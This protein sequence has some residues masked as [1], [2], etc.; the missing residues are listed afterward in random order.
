MSEVINTI[1]QTKVIEVKP[2]IR[3][4]A[5]LPA[6][7]DGAGLFT[8]AT[9]GTTLAIDKVRKQFY[10]IFTKDE[11]EAVEK[12]LNKKPGELDFYDRHNIFWTNF[13]V[14]ITKEGLKLDLSRIEDVI[15]YRI[16]LNDPRIAK[17]WT[18][19]F[20]DGRFKSICPRLCYSWII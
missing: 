16:L 7:H 1:L 18:D 17:S 11:R 6:E 3:G 10:Q 20:E 15:K 5:Y 19:R 14:N 12:E 9:W 2:I 8:G 13:K 4:N